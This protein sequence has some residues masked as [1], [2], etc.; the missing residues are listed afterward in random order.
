MTDKTADDILKLIADEQ[1]DYVDVRFCDLP[2]VMQHLSIPASAL[3]KAAFEDGLA[4]DG[5]SIRG[6][7]SIH[8][9]DMMLLPD[10]STARIDPFRAAKTLNLN[11]FVHDPFTREPYSRDPRNIARKA[12]SY[13]TST[14]IA[15][16]AYFGAEAEFYIFDSVSFDSTINGSFHKVDSVAGWWNTGRTTEAD[17]SPNLGYKVRPKGG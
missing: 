12:E 5:S 2:G 11:F 7:Q 13:L 8:E 1:I 17:G 10:F 14:G 9:S 3:D 15:D 16:T 4:F 6:F